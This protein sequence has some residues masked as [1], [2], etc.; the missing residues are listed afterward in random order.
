MTLFSTAFLGNYKYKQYRN[1]QSIDACCLGNGICQRQSAGKNAL[2]S[3]L[4]GNWHA[5]L[6]AYEAFT[7]PGADSTKTH[8]QTRPQQSGNPNQNLSIDRNSG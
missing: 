6:A 4:T 3:L 7:N 8:T 2:K 1:N 5:G